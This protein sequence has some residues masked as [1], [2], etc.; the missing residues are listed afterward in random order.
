MGNTLTAVKVRERKHIKPDTH[1]ASSDYIL[2]NWVVV[3]TE[4]RDFFVQR[5]YKPSRKEWHGELNGEPCTGYV[6][7]NV[8][9]ADVRD[10]LQGEDLKTSEVRS[11]LAWLA[12]EE[13][14]KA[15]FEQPDIEAVKILCAT[16]AAHPIPGSHLV[17]LMLIAPPGS[18]KTMV[19]AG[20]KGIPNI[21]RIDEVTSST[22][23]S[24]QVDDGTKK[25]REKPASLLHRIGKSGI[26]VMPDFS[27]LLTKDPRTRD[28]VFAQLRVIYDGE[29]HR[30]F[31]T[32][33]HLEE[34]TWEGRLTVVVCV[35]PAVDDYHA[36]FGTLGERFVCIR[37]DR[38][39]GID[40]AIR[41]MHQKSTTAVTLREAFDAFILPRIGKVDKIPNPA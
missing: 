24:G 2:P 36:V 33:E 25:R 26:V 37:W 11:Q 13:A 29:F 16:I 18:L 14:L 28:N 23:I 21:H 3:S 19:T 15:N 40:T 10:S 20:L 4:E 39:G 6:F 30:E 7:V 41:A 1:L 12:V 31:G 35:T 38:A 34:R 5:G 17:W 8:R 22:F 9:A 32:S 27:T